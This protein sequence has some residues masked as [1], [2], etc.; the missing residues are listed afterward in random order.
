MKD[1]QPMVPADELPESEQP[2]VDPKP[3]E[4]SLDDI[5]R[6]LQGYGF[7]QSSIS[8][9]EKMQEKLGEELEDLRIE[10]AELNLR[11]DEELKAGTPDVFDMLKSKLGF[12]KGEIESRRTKQERINNALQRVYLTNGMVQLLGSRRR[13]KVLEGII[14]VLIIFVLGL[15]VYDFTTPKEMG[16]FD[17]AEAGVHSVPDPVFPDMPTLASRLYLSINEL[18]EVP[19]EFPPDLFTDAWDR[20]QHSWERLGAMFPALKD[21]PRGE[22]DIVSA[23]PGWLSGDSIFWIDAVCCL[24]FMIEF[25]VRRSRAV[26]KSWFWRNHWIDFVTSIPIPG[27]AQLARFGR[28]AR[29]ARFARV[30]RFTRV[31]RALRVVMLLWRGMDKL[32]DAMDVK[33]MKRSLKWGVVVMAIGGILVWK[34]EAGMAEEGNDVTSAAGGMWWSFT[35]VV[36]GGFGDIHNPMTTVGR[37]LTVMLVI[38]GMILVGVFTATLTSLYVGEES[39][40]MQRH[41]DAMNDRLDRVESVLV[42]MAEHSGLTVD[43]P[44]EEED[45]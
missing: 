21:A 18:E 10:V 45:S 14:F 39:E 7:P 42:Q 11:V 36:T 34:I 15:L 32:Q 8:S 25:F 26:S 28:F 6:N 35:T 22:F 43:L 33:L 17:L 44:P 38:T 29:V 30:L 3:R 16:R 9:L 13:V 2:P 20:E 41:Q 40:E 27:E 5:L 31:L 12:L 37:L 19:Q 23:R 24:I 1:F 4:Q